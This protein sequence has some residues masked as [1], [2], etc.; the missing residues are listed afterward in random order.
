[1]YEVVIISV[2][3]VENYL[4]LFSLLEGIVDPLCHYGVNQSFVLAESV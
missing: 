4:F 1:M 2:F 3:T